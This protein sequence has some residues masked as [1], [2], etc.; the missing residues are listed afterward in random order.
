M[1]DRAGD[2]CFGGRAAPPGRGS[3]G[4][5]PMCRDGRHQ[6]LVLLTCP[7]VTLVP[8]SS[9]NA[10]TRAVRWG[11]GVVCWRGPAFSAGRRA[12]RYPATGLFNKR[13]N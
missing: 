8:E 13:R 6:A 9:Q 3:R 2:V 10:A 12:P 11:A 1:K 7:S 4:K 5:A